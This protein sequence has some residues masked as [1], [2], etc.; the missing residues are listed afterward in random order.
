MPHQPNC[1]AWSSLHR[2][3][4]WLLLLPG[5]FLRTS[6]CCSPPSPLVHASIVLCSPSTGRAC[7]RHPKAHRE[8]GL[9]PLRGNT[10]PPHSAHLTLLRRD[11]SPSVVR[12]AC[13]HR[14]NWAIKSSCRVR[15]HACN[16]RVPGDPPRGPQPISAPRTHPDRL[17]INVC[18]PSAVGL[19]AFWSVSSDLQ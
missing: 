11:H 2:R 12:N 10:N 5:S 14:H 7:S 1:S 3:P 16:S 4:H 17:L 19:I 13:H 9:S 18:W 15:C 8:P 6:R